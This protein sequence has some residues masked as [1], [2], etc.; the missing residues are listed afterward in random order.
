M[1]DILDRLG[2]VIRAALHDV[3]GDG[4]SDDDIR[5]VRAD[6][7]YADAWDELDAFLNTGTTERRKTADGDDSR[8]ADHPL[9]QL[10]TDYANLEVPFDAPLEEVTK[11]HR[12]LM[13]KY[14][15]DRHADSAERAQ[16][17]TEISKR[18][19]ESYERIKRFARL[20]NQPG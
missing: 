7:Y 8:S 1:S 4:P 13:R 12:R 15:P 18:L 20:R 3:T 16:T 14:H 5:N 2:R 17:A 6:A 19:N 11:A 9:A 10:R